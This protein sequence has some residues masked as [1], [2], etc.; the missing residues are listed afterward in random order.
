MEYNVIEDATA[1]ST[2]S[3]CI[4]QSKTGLANAKTCEL[5]K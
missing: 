5:A 1:G 4:A 2:Q 3:K